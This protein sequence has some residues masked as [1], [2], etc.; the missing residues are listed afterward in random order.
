[1]TER[2]TQVSVHLYPDVRADGIPELANAMERVQQLF[3]QAS[4]QRFLLEFVVAPQ[5]PPR[6]DSFN[7]RND[8]LAAD[9]QQLPAPVPPGTTW[10]TRL[11]VAQSSVISSDPAGV[12]FDSD[13]RSA[14]AVF[15][16]AIRDSTSRPFE[17][18]LARTIAHELGHVFNLAHEDGAGD[19]VMVG[20]FPTLAQVESPVLSSQNAQHLI[21]HDETSVRPG[22]S[23]FLTRTCMPHPPVGGGPG[24]NQ[25]AGGPTRRNRQRRPKVALRLRLAAGAVYS[26]AAVPTYVI[27]EPV[28]L[29]VEVVNDSRQTLSVPRGASTATQHL[30]LQRRESPGGCV[31]LLPPL[32]YC[33]GARRESR[34]N[35]PPGLKAVF[36]ETLLFRGGETVF[37]RVGTYR[38]TAGLRLR[39]RW[40]LSAAETV[41][42]APPEVPRHERSSAIAAAPDAGLFIELGGAMWL[43][44]AYEKLD[45]L[46]RD[47]PKFPLNRQFRLLTGRSEVLA[48]APT[49][50]LWRARLAELAL[51]R[52]AAAAVRAEAQLLL[53][54]DRAQEGDRRSAARL[55]RRLTDDLRLPVPAYSAALIRRRLADLDAP[56]HREEP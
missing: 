23:A 1:M 51:D 7:L 42:V 3:D 10:A 30:V 27:G 38:L 41:H 50:A 24:G 54:L 9:L 28:H 40:L 16:S 45:R 35:L 43:D 55:R 32:L 17:Q 44:R 37:P 18:L 6:A 26:R 4:Q 13:R 25:A 19:D 39:G 11:L 15:A 56:I 36:H 52:R 14:C 20:G 31:N 22:R 29:R 5:S 47:N 46:D 21:A 12:I 34:Q 53:L 2:R 49:P 48:E 8:E 33:G